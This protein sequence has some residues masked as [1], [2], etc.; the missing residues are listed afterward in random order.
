MQG[1]LCPARTVKYH[2]GKIKSLHITSEI[3][4]YP[5]ETHNFQNGRIWSFP[6]FMKVSG[7]DTLLKEGGWGSRIYSICND[8]TSISFMN[9]WSMTKN[10]EAATWKS[11]QYSCPFYLKEM[12]WFKRIIEVWVHSFQLVRSPIL[13]KC[14]WPSQK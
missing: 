13:V 14:S 7:N 5:Q 3:S 12:S 8:E 1:L 2:L 4:F 9:C 10:L 6:F 11:I